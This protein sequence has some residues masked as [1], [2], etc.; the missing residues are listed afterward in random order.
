MK[1]KPVFWVLAALAAVLLVAVTFWAKKYYDARYALED[2]YY[3]VV[4]LDYDLTPGRNDFNDRIT[5]YVLT[6]Y[7]AD[8]NA[9]ELD[10]EINIDAHNA[11]L[12][13]PGTFLR[14]SASRQI[15]LGRRA[16]DESDVPEK[17]LEK[18][19]EAYEPSSASS[20][21]EYADERTRQLGI[22][23]AADNSTLIYTYTY[24]DK[25]LAEDAAEL[26]DPMYQAQFRADQQARPE[27]TTIFLE[28]KLE[29][30]TEI[31]SQ[32]Y[33]QR[34]VFDYERESQER[35]F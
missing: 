1:K 33:N 29:D 12:Y 22:S 2:H 10:F 18:I 35:P 31:F 17:A 19:M 15:V 20:L 28:V 27:L 21:V 23:C 34:V 7:N 4:P 8:G 6:C 9:R 13:P 14:V 32:K 25:S 11:D 30:G 26:L 5:E 3:T 16:V 24:E